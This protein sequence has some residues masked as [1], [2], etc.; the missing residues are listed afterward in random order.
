MQLKSLRK[1]G[2]AFGLLGFGTVVSAL[3]LPGGT[4]RM[5]REL[6]LLSGMVVMA[7]AIVLEVGVTFVMRKRRKERNAQWVD[8]FHTISRDRAVER[9]E[10]SHPSPMASA[11]DHR[12]DSSSR[13]M[14][15]GD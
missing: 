2:L 1:I 6:P 7:L 8:S 10:D 4:P 13:G 11:P 14:R 9:G 15:R 3:L 5:V 12:E